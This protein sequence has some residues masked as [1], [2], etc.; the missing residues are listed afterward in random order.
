M[1]TEQPMSSVPQVKSCTSELTWE[2][3]LVSILHL[4]KINRCIVH[5]ILGLFCGT[6]VLV[7]DT[8]FVLKKVAPGHNFLM[9][10]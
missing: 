5:E 2:G 9:Q 8:H 4:K 10:F 3:S 7:S 1:R 6:C